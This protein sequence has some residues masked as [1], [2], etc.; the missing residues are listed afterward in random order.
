MQ[1]LD[2]KAR[3]P[4][5]L[6]VPFF[7]LGLLGLLAVP[8]AAAI[9][10]AVAL[11]DHPHAPGVLFLHLITLGFLAPTMM[12]AYYQLVPVIL[13]AP[14]PRPSLGRWILAGLA[15][16]VVV[17]LLGWGVRFPEAIAGGGILAGLAL[18]AFIAQVGAALARLRRLTLPAAG[19][20]GAL[21]ALAAV[22]LLGPLLALGFFAHALL[23]AHVA[24]ALA[25]WL[26]LTIL[27]ATYQLVPFFAATP[28]AIG[29]RFGYGPTALVA[30]GALLLALGA[31]PP[32]G[33]A[34]ACL[35]LALWAADMARLAR[36]GRQ[37]R[38]E[39][40]ARYTVLSIGL[41]VLTAAC[42]EADLL[43]AAIPVRVLALTGIL[44]APA[45]LIMAQLQKI[46]PF[47]AALEA[48]G[49]KTEQLFSRQAADR[50]LPVAALGLVGLAAAS[51]LTSPL[52]VRAAAILAA[53]AAAAYLAIQW[54]AF[55]RF[56]A[57]AR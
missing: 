32:V 43:G 19:F 22:G 35:G 13:H 51:A 20:V 41:L 29:P 10:P 1:P 48:R 23:V 39:P 46:L 45:L 30:A 53:A 3:P 14:I 33:G 34:A 15:A 47:L 42:A 57:S 36:H 2:F 8:I 5:A 38:R 11:S 26:L 25:G 12:G 27:G 40:V 44:A 50:L 4:G 28:P 9:D 31:A 16:G 21:L 52:G 55:R 17:F 49:V 18:Y 24:A 37:A 6:P 7:A 54:R 56:R